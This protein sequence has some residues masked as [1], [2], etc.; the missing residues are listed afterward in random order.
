MPASNIYA[1]YGTD[2]G[3]CAE[4]A[5]R[6]FNK[7]KPEEG[8]DFANDLIDGNADNAEH[9][10]EISQETIQAIQ[11]LPFFGGGK[12]VWLKRAT[13]MGSDRTSEAERAKLGVEALKDTL[14]AGLGEGIT[15]ILSAT[16]IDKRRSFYKWLKDNAT[17]EEHNKL[18]T[19]K[20]GWEEQVAHMVR[21]RGKELELQFTN[22]ALELF[23]MLAGEDTRQINVEINKL[24]LFLGKDRRTVELDDIRQMV[25]LSRAGLVF[26]VGRALQRRDG[27][28]ALELI[29]QQLDRGESAIAILRASLIPT[30]RNLFM[31][32]AAGENKKLPTHNYNAFAGA[33][34][35]LP[36]MDRA[37]L[38]QKKAGGVN[39]YPLF[40]AAKDAQA[41]PFPALKKAMES[42][43]EADRSLVTTSLDH[44]MVLHRLVV[45]LM[46]SAK[47]RRR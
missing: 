38:P 12:I 1:F 40:L 19:S 31:A 47:Q 13:F 44:R 18:D 26:E 9:A 17:L 27:A 28:R 11:T 16:G 33:L 21:K 20:D 35:K 25:P 5:L 23:V 6:L 39:A 36:E 32:R 8:D 37:W 15:F 43:L 22:D 42:C 3:A 46:S 30:I 34:D 45:E 41:F 14:A 7:L 29:D 4:A 2:D 24:D 10:Y